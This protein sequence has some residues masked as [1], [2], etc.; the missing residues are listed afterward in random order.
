MEFSIYRSSDRMMIER[1]LVRRSDTRSL[2][3]VC[4]CF[5]GDREQILLDKGILVNSFAIFH[6][7]CIPHGTHS[8]HRRPKRWMDGW[9]PYKNIEPVSNMTTTSVIVQ[10]IPSGRER[11]RDTIYILIRHYR[12]YI[13]IL[14]FCGSRSPPVAMP[15]NVILDIH[16][17]WRDPNRP[18]PCPCVWWPNN[19]GLCSSSIVKEEK[20]KCTRL[21]QLL[22]E[23]IGQPTSNTWVTRKDIIVNSHC[24][25]LRRLRKGR[26]M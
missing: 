16:L 11:E 15:L 7:I 20:K 2:V 26:K 25:R 1:Y 18:Q 6:W 13:I 22:A 14:D 5:T 17:I 23:P 19:E 9:I 3:V 24:P 12:L 10:W 4:Y 8:C 21:L